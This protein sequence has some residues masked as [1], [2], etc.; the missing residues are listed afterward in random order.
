MFISL[1]YIEDKQKFLETNL[2]EMINVR[3]KQSAS[4]RTGDVC[5]RYFAASL[6]GHVV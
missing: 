5:I 4:V 1:N 3:D 2:E 6:G